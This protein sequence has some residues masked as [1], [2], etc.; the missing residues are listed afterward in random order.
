MPVDNSEV[1]SVE[2]HI[3]KHIK[4]KYHRGSREIDISGVC[5]YDSGD[6][7]K[8]NSLE[9]HALTAEHCGTFEEI[10]E[11]PVRAARGGGS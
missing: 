4:T 6:G 9:H 1:P 10:L 8:R 3:S 5:M 11:Q 2:I 7:N